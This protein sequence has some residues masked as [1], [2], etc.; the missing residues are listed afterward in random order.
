MNVIESLEKRY[1]TRA[2]LDKTVEVDTIKRILAAAGRAP[3]G[4]NAQPWQ[5]AVVMGEKKRELQE[6][7]EKEFR[8]GVRG[9]MDYSYYP[10]QW[11]EP[12]KARRKACGLLMY[13][14]LDIKREDKER[15]HDQW[16]RRQQH[17]VDLVILKSDS[18]RLH[19]FAP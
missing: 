18:N 6:T 9:N 3:S 16:H 13:A 4:V 14:T 7:L 15:Q 1:S 8:S 11:D 12:Y 19:R 5:V 17:E 2:F 10:T